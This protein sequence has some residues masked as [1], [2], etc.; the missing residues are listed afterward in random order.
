MLQRGAAQSGI[1]IK[2]SLVDAKLLIDGVMDG[3]PAF[4][5]GIRAGWCGSPLRCSPSP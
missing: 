3:G 4:G 1:G 5:A 2:L